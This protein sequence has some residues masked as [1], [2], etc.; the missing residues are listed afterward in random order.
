MAVNPAD[1][2]WILIFYST[3]YA[4]D[5]RS[6][7]ILRRNG[8]K[9]ESSLNAHDEHCIPRPYKFTMDSLRL[10]PEFRERYRRDYRRA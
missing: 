4:D 9:Q 3:G 10:Q 5:A 8:Q 2:V 1:I 6:S 7:L